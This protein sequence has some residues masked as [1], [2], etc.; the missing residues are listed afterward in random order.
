MLLAMGSSSQYLPK[1]II[2]WAKTHPND[3][4]V[5]EA[6]HFSSRVSRYACSRDSDNNNF[7][8]EAFTLLHKNYPQ[9]EWTQ[10]TKYWF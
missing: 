5:P 1:V 4:R 8:H 2:A 6:L 9:S 7:S 10:K 3:P